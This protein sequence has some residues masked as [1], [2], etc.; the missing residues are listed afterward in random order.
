M[1]VFLVRLRLGDELAFDM[2]LVLF[3]LCEYVVA[4]VSAFAR[5]SGKAVT[6]N[7]TRR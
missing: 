5:V 3:S 2:T 4:L 7:K 6:T 1:S